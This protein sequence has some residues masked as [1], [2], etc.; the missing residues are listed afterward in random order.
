MFPAT[1]YVR[2]KI[3][4]WYVPVDFLPNDKKELSSG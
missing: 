1:V 2:L 3:W 4:D